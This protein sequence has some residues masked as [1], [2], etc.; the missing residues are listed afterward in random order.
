[1]FEI[2]RSIRQG[3]LLS[4]LLFI[5]VAEILAVSIRETKK[6]KGIKFQNY[7]FKIAQLADDTTLF[8]Q[9]L[10]SVSESISLFND[11]TTISE[12]RLNLEKTE[13]TPIGFNFQKNIKLPSELNKLKYNKGPFKTLGIWFSNDPQ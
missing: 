6:I 8:L 12:L 1:M 5:L 9:D 4:A 10:R 3:C 7:E 13:I 2:S 11:F